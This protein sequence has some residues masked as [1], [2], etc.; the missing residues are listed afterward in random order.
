MSD[1]DRQK[2]AFE[3]VA[4]KL[5]DH[6][7]YEAGRLM[8]EAVLKDMDDEEP[9]TDVVKRLRGN[10]FCGTHEEIL[11][12]LDELSERQETIRYVTKERAN[13]QSQ[14]RK[15]KEK[16]R[17]FRRDLVPARS[18]DD[19]VE[20]TIVV[21]VSINGVGGRWAS[22]RNIAES[23]FHRSPVPFAEIVRDETAGLFE[24]VFGGWLRDR[25]RNKR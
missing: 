24:D 20:G 5:K 13:A 11:R 4:E 8:N 21:R 25:D 22:I 6:P 7:D 23:V 3:V 15:E 19:Y 10:P 17:Q 14:V 12:L 9:L 1:D 18:I 2:K 16:M